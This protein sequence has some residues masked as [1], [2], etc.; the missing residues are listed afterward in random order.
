M[1][2]LGSIKAN[3]TTDR[4]KDLFGSLLATLATD[5]ALAMLQ[6]QVRTEGVSPF[7]LSNLESSPAPW[8]D[9]FLEAVAAE[10][11]SGVQVR[12][13]LERRQHQRLRSRMKTEG[14]TDLA[15]EKLIVYLLE[16]RDLGLVDWLAE[17]HRITPDGKLASL[18]F[19]DESGLGKDQRKLLAR[20][21]KNP[22]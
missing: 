17:R 19:S 8:V 20:A 13:A 9:K 10:S 6:E 22:R 7:V 3:L 15:D 18:A 14:N 4:Q 16:K 21:K 11:K 12:E 2:D 1:A 5:E